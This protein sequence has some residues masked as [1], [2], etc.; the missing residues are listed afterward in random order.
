MKK[1]LIVAF[2]SV[3][4]LSLSLTVSAD[5]YQTYQEIVF[6]EEDER[7]LQ[8]VSTEDFAAAL[9]S[10]G[11]KKMFGWKLAVL[12]KKQEVEF[13]SETKLKIFNNGYSTIK[14][15]ITLSTKVETKFQISST[16]SLGTTISGDIKKFKGSIDGTIKTEIGYTRTETASELYEFKIIVDP[17]TYV[18]IVMKGRGIVS[19]GVAR[20][21]FCWIKIIEGGWETFTVTT[22]YYEIVKERIR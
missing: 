5:E 1:G 19:N 3:L 13:L 7:L 20:N 4:V 9:A 6:V 10:L 14:H 22:E 18:T 21:Y 15:D 17:G 11:G 16:G 2:L 12:T 8:D